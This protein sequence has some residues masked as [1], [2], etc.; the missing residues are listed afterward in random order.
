MSCNAVLA[1]VSRARAHRRT[2]TRQGPFTTL[3]AAAATRPAANTD[4]A[5]LWFLASEP[6]AQ[7]ADE[8]QPEKTGKPSWSLTTGLTIAMAV[9]VIVLVLV[10][11]Q[12]MT[13]LLR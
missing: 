1:C 11:I 13:S 6:E 10:F 2:S 8:P 12:L 4:P 5:D 9:V 3:L 7:V